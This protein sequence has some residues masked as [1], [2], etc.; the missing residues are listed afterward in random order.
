MGVVSQTGRSRRSAGRSSHSRRCTSRPA[1]TREVGDAGHDVLLFAFAGNG[2]LAGAE[3]ATGSAA[4][5]LEGEE[6][7]LVAGADGVSLARVTLGGAT[8]LHAPMGPRERIVAIDAVEPGKATGQ[9][10][11]PGV[12]RPSQRLDARNDVRRLRPAGKGSLALPPLRRDRLDLAWSRPVSP[13][14]RRRAPRGRLRVP[15]HAARG[16]HRREHEPRSRACRA[17]DLHAGREPVGRISVARTSPR[18]MSIG[19]A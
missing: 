15:D 9:P 12:V 6:A 19:P 10:L 2:L 16:A 17:R 18:P 13:R 3:L 11:V 1:R 8:D 7:N 4:L 5:L 14:R